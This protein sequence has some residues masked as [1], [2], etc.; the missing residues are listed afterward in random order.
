[1]ERRLI[2]KLL[3]KEEPDEVDISNVENNNSQDNEVKAEAALYYGVY[4]P[5]E[6][7]PMDENGEVKRILLFLI[8]ILLHFIENGKFYHHI[9]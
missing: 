8:S 6:Y 2:N 7:Q 1:M 3:N 4:V 5:E 9:F